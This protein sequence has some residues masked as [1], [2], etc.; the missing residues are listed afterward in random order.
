MKTALW[1]KNDPMAVYFLHP[2]ELIFPHPEM[3]GEDGLVAIGGDLSEE[4]LLTAYR[5]GIFPWYNEGD[6][7]LWWS[8]DPRAVV[9]PGKVTISASMRQEM[10][11]FRLTVDT[12]FEQVIKA[13]SAVPRKGQDG[14]WITEDMVR[15]YIQLHHSGF[16]HSFEVWREGKLSGG[17]YG[18]S[19]GKCFFGESMFSHVPNASKFAFIRLSQI[20]EERA[21]RL[22]DCQVPNDHL[23]S[24]GCKTMERSK[25]LEILRKNNLEPT[26]RGS[27]SR[28]V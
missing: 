18:V 26:F 28:W 1:K 22:I 23:A 27:W 24:M 16:A 8:P 10:K 17:L 11:K 6:P 21:F 5:F 25:Y 15:A 3:A 12:V 7:V 20:L 19:L 9:L 2:Q 14:T 13:C 4:R